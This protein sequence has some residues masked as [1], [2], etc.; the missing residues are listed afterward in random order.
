MLPYDTM[1]VTIPSKGAPNFSN[2][3]LE[4]HQNSMF[5]I[6]TWPTHKMCKI[7]AIEF[8]HCFRFC[9]K[10]DISGQSNVGKKSFC[11][12]QKRVVRC[13]TMGIWI[14][15]R[16]RVNVGSLTLGPGCEIRKYLFIL[17]NPAI[18]N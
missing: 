13:A 11:T 1:T 6:T 2:F 9:V 8:H 10:M 16:T 3:Q 14:I 12:L 4:R 7:I 15:R 5:P 18:I 17:L